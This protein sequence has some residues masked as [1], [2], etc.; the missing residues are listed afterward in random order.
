MFN[1]S[2]HNYK[3]H[4]KQKKRQLVNMTNEDW[5][6]ELYILSSVIGKYDDMHSKVNEFR[7]NRPELNYVKCIE[8][9]YFELL[10]QHE[11]EVNLNEQSILN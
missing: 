3:V 9:S 6:E 4:Q 2:T 10:K 8:L 5:I 1:T 11:E 7:K